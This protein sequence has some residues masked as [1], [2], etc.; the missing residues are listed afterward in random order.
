MGL[1]RRSAGYKSGRQP[2]ERCQ[3]GS[4]A[5]T[6]DSSKESALV[7][8]EAPEVFLAAFP[9]HPSNDI[10]TLSYSPKTDL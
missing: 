8:K 9:H 4:E 1:D 7:R 2:A 3:M 10:T 6:V 5:S